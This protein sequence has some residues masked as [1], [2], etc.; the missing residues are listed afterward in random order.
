MVLWAMCLDD[1]EDNNTTR[2]A[3]QGGAYKQKTDIIRLRIFE[4]AL[5]Y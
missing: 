5:H 1:T 3:N 4:G 2:W